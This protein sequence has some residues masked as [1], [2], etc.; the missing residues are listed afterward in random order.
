MRCQEIKKLVYETYAD[1]FRDEMEK[2]ERTINLD[3][4]RN[5]SQI[6]NKIVGDYQRDT[7]GYIEEE[8]E[9]VQEELNKE[10]EDK[11]EESFHKQANMLADECLREFTDGV[12]RVFGKDKKMDQIKDEKDKVVQRY[13]SDVN[14]ICYRD[15]W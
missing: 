4:K 10:I 15:D 1:E 11:I 9:R 3:F 12:N 8:V 2:S 6:V 13:N 7:A 14:K 5:I